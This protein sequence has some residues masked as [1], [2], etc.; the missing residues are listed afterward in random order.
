M[1]FVDLV[2]F[3]INCSMVYFVWQNFLVGLAPG[4]E[5]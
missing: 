2:D 5:I 4:M 1:N 3:K